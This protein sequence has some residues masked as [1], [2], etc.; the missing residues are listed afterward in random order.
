[1]DVFFL[2]ARYVIPACARSSSGS[3][4]GKAPARD[5]VAPVISSNAEI[6]QR[7]ADSEF[8]QLACKKLTETDWMW[9]LAPENCDN[10]LTTFQMC[11]RQRTFADICLS[12]TA[13]VSEVRLMM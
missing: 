5:K 10:M 4:D 3:Q 12:L 8:D 1:M 11:A 9:V 7:Y 13:V 2:A 6:A